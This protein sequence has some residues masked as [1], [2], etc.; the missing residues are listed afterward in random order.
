MKEGTSITRVGCQ[1]HIF[2]TPNVN[3]ALGL[4]MRFK[5]SVEQEVYLR[6]ATNAG[7]VELVYAGLDI[8]GSTPWKINKPI[9]DV[10]LSVWNSGV[11]MGKLPP[12]VYDEPEPVLDPA[13]ENDMEEKRNHIGRHKLWAQFKANNHS[14]RCSVNYKIEIARAVCISCD[15]MYVSAHCL[16]VVLGRCIISTSQ[17]RLPRSRLPDPA[18]SQPHWR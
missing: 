1:Y 8:L 9:F 4:A 7:A 6:E 15:M 16:F 12:A 10:V 14:E 5:D 2:Y 3:P 18:A 17:S 13:K 11:R